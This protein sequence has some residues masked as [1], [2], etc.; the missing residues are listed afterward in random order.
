MSSIKL[1]KAS[2]ID[3]PFIFYLMYDGSIDGA[4][5]GSFVSRHG[6][7]YL[8]SYLIRS[9]IPFKSYLFKTLFI[10]EVFVYGDNQYDFGFIITIT[11]PQKNNEPKHI[12]ICATAIK[13]QHR[14]KGLGKMMIKSFL[15][16]LDPNT[17]VHAYC[18]KYSKVMQII[19]RKLKF[20]RDTKREN[21]LEH[22]YIIIQN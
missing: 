3:L 13:P 17:E 20:I 12:T 6:S 16:S 2:V 21:Q 10:E 22:F 15:E 1:R 18:T 9:F 7:V 5:T 11:E 8:F 4:F 19:F 14:K